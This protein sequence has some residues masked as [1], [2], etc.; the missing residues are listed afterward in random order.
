MA[1]KND[2]LQKLLTAE[3]MQFFIH[4]Q[5]SALLFHFT[6]MFARHQAVVSLQSDGTFLQFRSLGYMRCPDSHPHLDV[7]L[8]IL[9]HIN[10]LRKSVK[11]GWDPADGEIV[12]YV[13]HA[14]EDGGLTQQQFHQLLWVFL[15][16]LDMSSKRLSEALETGHDPGDPDPSKM[17]GSD[18]GRVTSL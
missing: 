13:D 16:V 1:I 4:P 18:A 10:Y 15:V 2:D 8:K 11:F 14:I 6:G 7:I 5:T 17:G 9:G 12:G 3:G